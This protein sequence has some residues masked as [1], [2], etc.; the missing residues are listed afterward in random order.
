MRACSPWLKAPMPRLK[1]AVALFVGALALG[2]CDRAATQA[3]LHSLQSKDPGLRARAAYKLGA[4]GP[5]A[6]AAVPALIKA[7]DD[8]DLDARLWA[9][10]ALGQIGPDAAPACPRLAVFLASPDWN[11][12]NMAGLALKGIGPAS[13][14]T[15]ISLLSAEG[16]SARQEAAKTLVEFG[17]EALPALLKALEDGDWKARYW[18][19]WALGAS[20][21]D[22]V[23]A[24][25]ALMRAA[26]QDVRPEVRDQA[27]QALARGGG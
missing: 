26:S 5:S 1:A 23:S 8:S 21:P 6:R 24:R 27:T 22:D 19:A 7:L 12:R 2:A 20:A 18:A 4:L 11:Q 9:M 14:P 17:L 3:S 10:H 25:Q 15:L 13:L 16:R